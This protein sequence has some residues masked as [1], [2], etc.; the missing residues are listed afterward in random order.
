MTYITTI[1]PLYNEEAIIPELYNRI[2]AALEQI[3]QDWQIIFVNDG[4]HDNTYA[5]VKKITAIDSKVKF[6]S[7]ARNFGHQQ[8]VS[9]GLD[10]CSSEV[11]V[12]I[13]GDLQDPPELIPDM[14]AKYKEGYDVVYAQR[15]RREGE[16][17]F[18]KFTAKIF[19]RVM[20]SI[21][22]FEIPL[23]TGDYRLISSRVVKTLTSMDEKNKF[24]RGQI[25]WMGYKSCGVQFLRSERKY[26]KTEYTLS[27]MIRLALNG[28]TGFSD[29]PLVFVSQL[30]IYISFVALLILI[31]ALIS[32]FI[33]DQTVTGW[34]SIIIVLSFLGGIQLLALGILGTYVSRIYTNLLNRPLY[35]IDEENI[36]S[37]RTS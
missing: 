3:S 15:A 10:H 26:G 25:A 9:A 18:K 17:F 19:Y 32:H 33:L 8:A 11:T 23:D 12:I 22:D 30:G 36:T 1:V 5:E 21:T 29:R 31:Y 2:K 28:I 20:K 6:I 16:T 24:L 37:E 34:T 35:I 4:S 7:F 14:H 27:K 13:D